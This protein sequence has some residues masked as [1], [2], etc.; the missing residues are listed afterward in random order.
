MKKK[1]SDINRQFIRWARI[2]GFF[3]MFLGIFLGWAHSGFRAV[4]VVWEAFI[5]GALIT[6]AVLWLKKI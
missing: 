6:I 2:S 4:N 5:P 1:S 3:L